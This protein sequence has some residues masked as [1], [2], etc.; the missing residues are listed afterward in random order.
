MEKILKLDKGHEE[1]QKY[2]FLADTALAKKDIF[3]MIELFRA[4]E[5][6]EDLLAVLSHIDSPAVAGQLQADHTLLFNGYDGIKSVMSNKSVDFSSR[7]EARASF[8][9]LLSAVYKKD[10]QRK[11]VFEGTKTWQ[12]K[13]KDKTWKITGIR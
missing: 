7:W 10:G 3:Q 6:S 12:L 11:I 13:K 2:L 9:H 4:A 8:S 5:E 1:A